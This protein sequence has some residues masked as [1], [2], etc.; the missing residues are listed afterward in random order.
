MMPAVPLAPAHANSGSE[1]PAGTESTKG[2]V[3][4]LHPGTHATNIRVEPVP[5]SGAMRRVVYA[6]G[7]VSP[8]ANRTRCR[9]RPFAGRVR[10]A[11]TRLTAGKSSKE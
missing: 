11:R 3:L 7:V 10:V 2:E 6:D 8:M 9:Q 5:E 1:G 4:W